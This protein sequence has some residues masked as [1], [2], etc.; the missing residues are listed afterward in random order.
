MNE[1]WSIHVIEYY[2]A[3]AGKEALILQQ[4]GLLK[5]ENTMLREGKPVVKDHIFYDSIYM[6]GLK[7]ANL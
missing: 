4:P 6:K 7:K 3:L 5:L 1:M 2:Q